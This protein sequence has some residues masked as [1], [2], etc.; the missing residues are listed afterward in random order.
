ML[1]ILLAISLKPYTVLTPASLVD[2]SQFVEAATIT[3]RRMSIAFDLASSALITRT[4]CKSPLAR[5]Y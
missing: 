1:V 5:L 2:T 3:A 4:T